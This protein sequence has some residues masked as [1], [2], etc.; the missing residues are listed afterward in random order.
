MIRKDMVVI[1]GGG[2][3]G[4]AVPMLAV[5]EELAKKYRIIIFGSHSQI[6]NR[7]FINSKIRRF[8]II[9][10]KIHRHHSL[11]AY[12]GNLFN[13]VKFGLGLFQAF[14]I[15]AVIRPKAIFSKGGYA[16]LPTVI[17]GWFLKIPTVLHESDL[18]LGMANRISL[19]YAQKIAVSFPPENYNLSLE[20]VVYSGH[21]LRSDNADLDKNQ[22][23]KMK[24]DLNFDREKT[25]LITGGSQGALAINKAVAKILPELLKI[26]NI[27]HISGGKDYY[28]LK[29]LKEGLD[30]ARNYHLVDYTTEIIQFIA[31]SDL[32]ITRAGSNSLAEIAAL[33]KPA[34]IIPYRYSAAGHQSENAR[35]FQRIGGGLV[36]EE[37]ELTSVGLLTTI[38]QFLAD[39]VKLKL[40]GENSYRG[41]NFNGAEKI[42]EIISEVIKRKCEEV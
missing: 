33:K 38:K 28:W 5:A 17:A 26:A 40:A 29:Q 12:F 11:K 34:I 16:A 14:V 27:I 1:T 6:E 10:G 19:K 24:A 21:I 13:I 18:L 7:V 36:I 9:S 23:L 30:D 42:A 22:I 4:H 20:K 2:T 39:E 31:M 15:L 25:I 3:G 37:K 35:Y 41:N 8:K 32:A